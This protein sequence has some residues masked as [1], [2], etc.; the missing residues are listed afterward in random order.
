MA[1]HHRCPP[2]SALV[3]TAPVGFWSR[4]LGEEVL[5]Q[6]APLA[7][8]PLPNACR[9]GH[10]LALLTCSRSHVDRV[11]WHS[12]T[13]RVARLGSDAPSTSPP[14]VA[15][16]Q[17]HVRVASTRGCHGNHSLRHL[18]SRVHV[19]QTWRDRALAARAEPSRPSHPPSAHAAIK[20]TFPIHFV[21]TTGFAVHRYGCH[22]FRPCFC[23]R[24]T[25]GRP[26]QPPPF[27]LGR[28]Q[29]THPPQRSFPR[30]GQLPRPPEPTGTAAV[31]W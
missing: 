5:E 14:P 31:H 2:A 25:I 1:S 10:C 29:S 21:R 15:K 24:L 30:H 12:P 9:G 27:F 3:G 17:H 11:R 28:S 7:K 19:L 4:P 22:R 26:N 16:G 23:D 13:C 8:L 18:R 6:A 20:G